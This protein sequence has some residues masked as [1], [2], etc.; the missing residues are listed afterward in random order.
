VERQK[1]G[2]SNRTP[3]QDPSL[4]VGYHGTD[5][6]YG[7]SQ[8]DAFHLETPMGEL[9]GTGPFFGTSMISPDKTPNGY[10]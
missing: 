6:G 2:I 7:M 3:V 5:K 10:Q 1:K 8:I 9:E 4:I